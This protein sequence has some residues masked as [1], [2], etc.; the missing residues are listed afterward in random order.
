[1]TS[2]FACP[3][4]LTATIRPDPNSATANRDEQSRA[5]SYAETLAWSARTLPS[6]TGVV[7]LENSV[8]D[9]PTVRA[10]QRRLEQRSVRCEWHRL[11]EAAQTGTPFRGKGWGEGRMLQ[12]ALTES[13]LVAGQDSFVK[14]TGRLRLVNHRQVF[15]TIRRGRQENPALDFVVTVSAGPDR[16]AVV[17]TQFFWT[18]REFYATHLADAY[19][20]TDD[21]SGIYLEHVFAKRLRALAR[22][23]AVYALDVPLLIDGVHGW[24]GKKVQAR[25]Y[26]WRL[27]LHYLLHHRGPGMTRLNDSSFSGAE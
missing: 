17:N 26:Q 14:L 7:L 5:D 4:V 10:A 25:H 24:S 9:H 3:W 16:R 2:S 18:R 13:S 22:D 11:A 20:E 12:R 23:H 19:R 27:R 21:A 1:M 8:S 6:A 15:R